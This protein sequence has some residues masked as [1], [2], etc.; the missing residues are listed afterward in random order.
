MHI[1]KIAKGKHSYETSYYFTGEII[2]GPAKNRGI[3][4]VISEFIPT[5]CFWIDNEINYRTK[6][7]PKPVLALRCSLQAPWL[8]YEEEPEN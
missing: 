6:L 3:V 1:G 7:F 4:G 8:I 2:S 5:F